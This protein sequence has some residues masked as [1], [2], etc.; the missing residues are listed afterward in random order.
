MTAICSCWG[1]SH[2]KF[3]LL[4]PVPI[5]HVGSVQ[6]LFFPKPVVVWSMF[7]GRRAPWSWSP[8]VCTALS[9]VTH[10]VSSCLVPSCFSRQREAANT[11]RRLHRQQTQ[12]ESDLEE[13][14]TNYDA[15][16]LE[17]ARMDA[18]IQ[19]AAEL[20]TPSVSSFSPSPIRKS[21]GG[22]GGSDFPI[23]HGP[24]RG[25][26]SER[27]GRDAT[28]MGA[29]LGASV[30]NILRGRLWTGF[31]GGSGGG[32]VGGLED[33]RSPTALATAGKQ[34]RGTGGGGKAGGAGGR[35]HGEQRPGGAEVL[36]AGPANTDRE[37]IY[38]P[39]LLL[40]LFVVS[41]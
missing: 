39:L 29:G 7:P 14:Q 4:V 18:S 8:T 33:G 32:G 23:A 3:S 24:T 22:G 37:V 13:L 34:E 20:N 11:Q 35:W 30:G 31:G 21:G 5:P 26:I 2:Q 28:A 10:V 36:A 9:L 6:F 38:F 12:L 1:Q 41:G 17:M 15:L 27:S 40:L 25:A 19:D 16:R